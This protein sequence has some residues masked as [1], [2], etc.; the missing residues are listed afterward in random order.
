MA[1]L[2]LEDIP[3]VLVARLGQVAAANHRTVNEEVV[4]R[5]ESAL[6]ERS[7]LWAETE[8]S[9]SRQAAAGVWLTEE[10]LDA[11]INEGRAESWL[12]RRFRCTGRCTACKRTLCGGLRRKIRNGSPHGSGAAS[13]ATRHLG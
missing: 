5:I 13:S 10:Q 7:A 1:T 9:L 11:Y 3:D 8:A 4:C 12:I 6:N 2:V